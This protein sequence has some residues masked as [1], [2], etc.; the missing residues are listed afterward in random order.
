[1]PSPPLPPPQYAHFPSHLQVSFVNSIATV[2]GGTHVNYVADQVTKFLLDKSQKKAGKAAA[3]SLK[4]HQ[5][6]NHL[7]VFVNSLIVNPAFDSQTKETLN[8]RV[9]EFGST[10]KLP[11]D[12]LKKGESRGR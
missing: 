3:G 5:V 2:K 8:T 4:A 9:S 12:F 7:W 1:M 10:C 11:E 6:K